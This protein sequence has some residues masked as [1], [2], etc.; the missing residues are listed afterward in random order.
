MSVSVSKTLLFPTLTNIKFSDL[1]TSFKET[2][3]GSISASEYRRNTSTSATNPIVPDATENASVSTAN[4]LRLSQFQNTIKYYDLNQTGTDLN[5]DLFAQTWN[6]NL[7]KNIRKR[8]NINGTCGS[9]SA[10]S[11]AL[12]LSGIMY[13]VFLIINGTVLGAGGASNSGS[14]GSAMNLNSGGNAINVNTSSTALVYGGGGGGAVGATGASGPAGTCYYFSDYVTG[15]ACGS[16]P[17]CA[18]GYYSIGCNGVSGCN[19]GKRGCRNTNYQSTCRTNVFYNTAAPAGGA[20]GAGGLGQGYNQTRTNGSGGSGGALTDCAPNITQTQTQGATG[21]TGG[22]GGDWG[23]NG[24]PT[25]AAG[26]GSTGRAIAGSNYIVDSNAVTAA[27]R[28]PR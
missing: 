6:S 8:V 26:G 13:N 10:S 15:T 22:N 21:E 1:R 11:A 25:T 19:C 7:F 28:G 20:G 23:N 27:F 14:G 4:N 16:C 18:A 24:S 17:G 3:D 2:P 5:L 9:N 12:N